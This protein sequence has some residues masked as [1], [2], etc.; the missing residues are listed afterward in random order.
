[1]KRYALLL[2]LLAACGGKKP[3]TGPQAV[4]T[5]LPPANPLAVQRMVEGSTAAKDPRM[6]T[7]AVALLREAIQIDPNLWEAHFD[8]GVV[9]ASGGD[10]AHA[11]DALKSAAKIAPDR[12]EVAFALAAVRRRRG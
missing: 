10:L 12:E 3:A 4:Q 8:L 1:M 2:L 11:E 6:Q 9:L 7:R 5:G